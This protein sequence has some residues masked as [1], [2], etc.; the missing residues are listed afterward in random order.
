VAGRFVDVDLRAF[1]AGDLLTTFGLA[2]CYDELAAVRE[3]ARDRE[4]PF[5][6]SA[7]VT[8]VYRQALQAFGDVDGE[9]RAAAFLEMQAGRSLRAD[10]PR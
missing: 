10:L 8:E 6:V 1:L 5:E 9:L 7:A 4:T 3:L 2:A